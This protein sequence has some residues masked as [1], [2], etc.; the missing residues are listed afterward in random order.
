M[1]DIQV[2]DEIRMIREML[3]KT[4]RATADSGAFL[5]VWGFLIILAVVGNYALALAKLYSWIWLN[6]TAFPVGGVIYSIVYWS[7]REKASGTKTYASTAAGYLG[8]SCGITF[9]FVGLIIPAFKLYSWGAIAP[10][11]SVIW[12][13]L[14]FTLGGIFEWNLLKWAGLISW[15]VAFG[16]IFIR[17]EYRA[18]AFV[19]LILIGYIIPGFILRSEYKREQAS[20]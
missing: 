5:L 7:R 3:E 14:V 4:R 11:I 10:L 16:M 15:L 1:N 18:L 6:W 19:P 8:L 12:A 2:K 9:M 17:E 20:K 13:T